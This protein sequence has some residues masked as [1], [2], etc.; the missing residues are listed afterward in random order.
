MA[1]PCTVT[2]QGCFSVASPLIY[3]HM[4]VSIEEVHRVAHLARIGVSDAEAPK[5]AEQLTSILSYVDRLQAVDTSSVKDGAVFTD[6]LPPDRDLPRHND[7]EREQIIQGF[8][9]R[10]AD[11]L[12]VPSVFPNRSAK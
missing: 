2:V 8:P 4:S 1:P 6:M 3:L 12:R 7:I 10:M 11:L 9:D 5:F